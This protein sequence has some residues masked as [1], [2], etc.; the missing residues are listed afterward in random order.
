M[1]EF[2]TAGDAATFLGDLE[3]GTVDLLL[4]DPPYYGIVQ[5]GWD[6]QWKD[7]RHFA[8]WLSRILLAGLPKLSPTGSLVFFGALGRHKSHPLFRVVMALEDGGYCYRNWVTWKK[9]R[10]YGKSHDYLYTR[11]EIL[12]FSRSHERTEVTFN[13]PYTEE[14]RGY[15]GFD[16]KYKAHSEFKRVSNVWND[17]DDPGTIVDTVTELFRPERV[18]QKPIKLMERLL[19]THSNEGDM[20]VDPFSGWGSTGVATTRLKRR[21]RGCEAIP[22]DAAAANGRV[23]AEFNAQAS[24]DQD[25]VMGLFGD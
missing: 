19:L 18:C 10:A 13:K 2:V 5:D 6:N 20:V 11:E 15:D 9:R 17:I 22:E 14:K 3:D 23:Q 8:D 1:D 21:F 16:E 25:D 4:T 7:D 24:E 12:W